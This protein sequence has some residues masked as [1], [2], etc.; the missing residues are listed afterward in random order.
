MVCYERRI[1]INVILCIDYYKN[2]EIKKWI[3]R[4]II[5]GGNERIDECIFCIFFI[6]II[7]FYFSNWFDDKDFC[8]CNLF[9]VGK[10]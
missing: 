10:I 8:W 3:N 4:R 9:R 2:K 1:R 6:S 5:N 7:V